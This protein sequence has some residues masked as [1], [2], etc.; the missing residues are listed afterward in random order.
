MARSVSIAVA[1]LLFAVLLVPSAASEQGGGTVVVAVPARAGHV[2]DRPYNSDEFIWRLFCQFAAPVK[3]VPQQVVFETWATD[4]DTFTSNP[5]WPTPGEPK[6]FHASPLGRASTPNTTPI[7]VPCSPPPGAAVGAFPTSGTPVPC[8]A[9][10][11]KR[12]KPGFDYLVNNKLNT[13]A[14]RAEAYAKQF[15][16]AMPKEAIAVKGD[17]VPIQTIL[18]WVPELKTLDNVRKHYYRTTSQDVEYGLVSLHVSSRQNPNWVWGSFEHRY[19][20]GRC[21]EIG[22]FDTFGAK[23]PAVRPNKRTI[24]TQ[25]GPCEKTDRLMA[26]MKK[27]DLSPVWE[28]YCLKSTEVDYLAPDG[29]PYVLGNSVIE[30]ITGNGTVAASSCIACHVYASFGKD[31]QPTNAALSILPYNPTGKPIP[32]VLQDALQLDF[33]WG[34]ITQLPPPPPSCTPPSQCVAPPSK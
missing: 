24:N 32:A 27:H 28:N 33:M 30:R 12:N 25:Y 23:K 26:L 4:E 15:K 11:V 17:W 22:C 7:D 14:G 29:T 19:T 21:D 10:E 1:T 13:P 5:H 16:V 31:G 9:E 18:Q 20:P 3:G 34:L 6:K 2:D 8:I